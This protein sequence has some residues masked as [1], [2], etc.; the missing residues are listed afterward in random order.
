MSLEEMLFEQILLC[1][2]LLE[3]MFQP[4]FFNLI[5]LEGNAPFPPIFAPRVQEHMKLLYFKTKNT[6]VYFGDRSLYQLAALPTSRGPN[7]HA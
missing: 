3:Q 5:S 7:L 2:M 4:D 6:I 1:Q